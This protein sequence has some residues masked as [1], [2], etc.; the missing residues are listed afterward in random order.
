M[1]AGSAV[2]AY[3]GTLVAAAVDT[4]TLQ[5]PYRAVQ[6]VNRGSTDIF[7]RTDGGTPTVAGAESYVIPAN[8]SVVLP[9][10]VPIADNSDASPRTTSVVELIS[11]GTPAYSVQGV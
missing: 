9:M 3:H 7:V 2:N 8:T 1:A 10:F 4:V 6:F 5:R 11:S